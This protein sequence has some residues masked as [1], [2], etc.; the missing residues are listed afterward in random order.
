M[1][2]EG[3]NPTVIAEAEQL[4]LGLKNHNGGPA[5]QAKVVRQ[6]EKIRC[7]VHNG[8]DSLLFHAQPVR[9]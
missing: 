7:L 2:A 4:L 9:R 3:I 6:L 5:Y 1:G 8:F